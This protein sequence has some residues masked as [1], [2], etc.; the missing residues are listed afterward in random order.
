[1]PIKCFLAMMRVFARLMKDEILE[2]GAQI[3]QIHLA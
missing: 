3:T 2:T 1:M